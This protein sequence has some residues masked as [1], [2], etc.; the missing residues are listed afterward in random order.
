MVYFFS[1]KIPTVG[2]LI[3]LNWEEVVVETVGS[4]GKPVYCHFPRLYYSA[5]AYVSTANL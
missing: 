4:S 2:K 3:A 1:G 5:R